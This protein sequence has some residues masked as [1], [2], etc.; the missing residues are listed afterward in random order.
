[1]AIMVG[2]A[3]HDEDGKYVNGSAGDSLQKSSTTD[4]A[5]EVSMQ[6]MYNHSKGWYI[7][8]PKRVDHANA[9]AEKMKVACNNANIGYDQNNRLGVITYG[10]DTKVKTECDCSSLVRECV[11][12]ATGKD[13]GNFTTANEAST[14]EKSGLFEKK[15]AYVSQAKTPV[16]DGDVLV[17]KTKGHTVIVVSG[18]PRSVIT[19]ALPT[20][21]T[22][23]FKVGDT[24]MFTGSLHYTNSYSSGIAR[25]CRAGLAKITKITAGKSHPYHLKAVAGKGSTV[26]GWV[27]EKDVSKVTATSNKTHVVKK[28]ETLSGIANKYDTT[29][30]KLASLNGIKNPSL[31]RVGQII[32]LP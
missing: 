31:I 5:G 27:N 29:V 12:E 18:N 8:R 2:S 17:T 11:K 30:N 7:L 10:V 32:K 21:S 14:L 25:G 15:V 24:V 9:I 23:E 1:M 6:K 26:N 22:P 20:T 13:V 4:L 16:Y 19:T 28:G 3:R